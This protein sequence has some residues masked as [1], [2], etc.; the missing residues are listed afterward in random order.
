M[1][2]IRINT[3]DSSEDFCSSVL[4]SSPYVITCPSYSSNVN[5]EEDNSETNINSFSSLQYTLPSSSSIPSLSTTSTFETTTTSILPSSFIPKTLLTTTKTTTTT[6]PT[7]TDNPVLAPSPPSHVNPARKLHNF[8]HHVHFVPEV[9]NEDIVRKKNLKAVEGHQLLKIYQAVISVDENEIDL[10]NKEK[11]SAEHGN[12][13]DNQDLATTTKSKKR[14]SSTD[15]D[16]DRNFDRVYHNNTHHHNKIKYKGETGTEDN[17]IMITEKRKNETM[18]IKGRNVSKIIKK[19]NDRIS[20]QQKRAS[21]I[22]LNS[23]LAHKG[24]YSNN[25]ES[26]KNNRDSYDSNGSVYNNDKNSQTREKVQPNSKWNI[27]NK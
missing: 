15:C 14:P 16:N 22:S 19:K 4:P 18:T 21:G 25:K 12:N 27:N 17:D 26:D 8:E 6:K 24:S 11:S 1:E 23:H 13:S 2:S 3:D 10:K 7:I 9:K 20:S 5:K